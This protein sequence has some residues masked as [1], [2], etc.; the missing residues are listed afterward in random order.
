MT[1]NTKTQLTQGWEPKMPDNLFSVQKLLYA[2]NTQKTQLCSSAKQLLHHIKP[3]KCKI[4]KG[5]LLL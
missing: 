1:P 5:L 2:G 3:L 4:L